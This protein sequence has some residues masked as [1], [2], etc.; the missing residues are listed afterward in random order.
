MLRGGG[1]SDS[2]CDD[3]ESDVV[4][5]KVNQTI[6]RLLENKLAASCAQKCFEPFVFF[7]CYD[8][9]RMGYLCRWGQLEG[10]RSDP[11][12]KVNMIGPE[13]SCLMHAVL[14]SFSSAPSRLQSVCQT[15]PPYFL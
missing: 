2:S 3:D 14:G 15:L 12:A 7:N 11:C 5:E 8:G 10:T 9:H 1:S 6:P 4:R 13:I